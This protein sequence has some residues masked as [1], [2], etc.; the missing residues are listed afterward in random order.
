MKTI[1]TL[2][3]ILMTTQI[4]SQRRVA[5]VEVFTHDGIDAAQYLDPIN[6]YIDSVAVIHWHKDS[7]ETEYRAKRRIENGVWD[8]RAEIHLE[9]SISVD[10]SSWAILLPFCRDSILGMN[11]G[12]NVAIFR[13]LDNIRVRVDSN[14][15][16]FWFVSKVA[17]SDQPYFIHTEYIEPGRFIY[18][19]QPIKEEVEFIAWIQGIRET[20]NTVIY[21]KTDRK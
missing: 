14:G 20:E 15:G 5:L 18:L 9:G 21:H 13:S 12:A 10:M 17:G 11:C 1:S 19:R 2:I 4:Y 16:Y 6:E 7:T 3:L 8:S